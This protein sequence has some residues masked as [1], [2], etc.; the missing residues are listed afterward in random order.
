MSTMPRAASEK[1]PPR[2]SPMTVYAANSA[3]SV[4]HEQTQPDVV[5][6]PLPLFAVYVKQWL[7]SCP[8]DP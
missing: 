6:Q 2:L 7:G 3:V 5:C 8:P 1:M 4:P